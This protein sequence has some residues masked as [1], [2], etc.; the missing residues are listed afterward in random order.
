MTASTT[1]AALAA[2]SLAL[3]CVACDGDGAAE[4]HASSFD[5]RTSECYRPY[6]CAA[7]CDGPT[8]NNGCCQCPAGQL[9][10]LVDCPR[11][12]AGCEIACDDDGSNCRC[13]CGEAT[14]AVT[15]PAT[16]RPC[17]SDDDCLA[18][19]DCECACVPRVRSIPLPEGEAWQ[20]M[21]D[22]NPPPNCG[23]SSPCAELVARCDTERSVCVVEPREPAP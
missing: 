7:R 2:L 9:D 8:T 20:T 16:D 13:E 6:V 11:C 10:V 23:A 12:E 4:R 22:G 15:A 21:C 17:T 5:C 1:H 3:V 14:E 18:H 19:A